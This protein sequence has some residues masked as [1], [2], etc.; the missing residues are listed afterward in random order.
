MWTITKPDIAA[1]ETFDICIEGIR[2]P[3][4]KARLEGIRQQIEDADADFD[5]KG[6]AG[7]LYMIAQSA[8]VIGVGGAVTADEMVNLYK[9]HMSRQKSRGRTIYDKIMAAAAYG[10]CPFCGHLPV[11]TLD[12]FHG[13]AEY[14]VLAV[15][16]VNLIPCCKDCNDYKGTA[17]A[18][19]PE[20]QF[21]NAYYDDLTEDRWLYAQII[22]GSPPG[23]IFSVIPPAHWGAVTTQRVARHFREL[24]LAKLYS[25]QSSRQLQNIRSSLSKNYAAGGAAAVQADLLERSDSCNVVAI[26]SWEGALFEAAANDGWYCG[27]GFDA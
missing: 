18:L 14:P 8:D 5:I 11:S 25:S 17:A 22:H 1:L 4:L 12:H 16:P 23:A 27:G 19:T 13:K 3:A 15:T 24:N 6:L 21:L 2:N 20:T 26:N 10:Q 7:Q 9:R